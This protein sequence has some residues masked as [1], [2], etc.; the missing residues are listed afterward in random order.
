MS[1]LPDTGQL[2]LTTHN[3]HNRQTYMPLA[4]FEPEIPASELLQ[5]HALVSLS[6][7]IGS[8]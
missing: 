2:S 8:K 6:T 5:T 7:G 1:D 3:T 4:L